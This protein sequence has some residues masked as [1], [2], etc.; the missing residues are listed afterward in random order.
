MLIKISPFYTVLKVLFK[1]C[2]KMLNKKKN[3]SIFI[4][5]KIYFSDEDFSKIFTYCLLTIY[6]IPLEQSS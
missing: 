5:L 3:I 4:P 6:T 2:L 1:F